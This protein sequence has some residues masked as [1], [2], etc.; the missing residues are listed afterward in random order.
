LEYTQAIEYLKL[1]KRLGI[2]PGLDR[3]NKLLGL[4]GDPQRGLPAVHVAGTNG[5]GSV[6]SYIHAILSNAGYKA[7][8]FTS[9]FLLSPC[10]M[11][12]VDDNEI[13][14]AS[15]CALV[16]EA[17]DYCLK[18]DEE[19]DSPS[20][21]EI[22]TAIALA[23]FRRS[24][25][26]IAVIEACMGGRFDCTNVLDA[27]NAA[28][29]TGI[30]L[31]H[32]GFL[33][34]SAGKIAWHKVGIA[35]P[36]VPVISWP[37]DDEAMAVIRREAAGLGSPVIVP[38]FSGIRVVSAG[39]EGS[40]FDYGDLKSLGIRMAGTHQI[41]N[42]ALAIETASV[43]NGAGWG[44][45]DRSIRSGL[46]KVRLPARFELLR[47]NPDFILDCAHNPDGVK[48]FMRTYRE[49]Y[50]DKKAVV[51]FGV[52]GDKDYEDMIRQ[53]SAISDWFFVVK[54]ENDRALSL[55]I[56]K[57]TA[58]MYCGK[59]VKSDTINDVLMKCMDIAKNNGVICALG[60]IYYAGRVR[61]AVLGLAG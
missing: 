25:C 46:L 55:D 50:G 45:N 14:R 32:T 23:H 17:A 5:K 26:N 52:M 27:V 19:G 21:Y 33:G 34:R 1:R 18:L 35:K 20:E 4:F 44:I 59:V 61:E 6:S 8:L 29:I 36:G 22:Y 53:V 43:L 16:E 51:I 13:D 30:S 39:K 41:H 2:K 60:S 3:I 12:R 57:E 54:P 9:P 48:E 42:A 47:E 40:A 28:V 15:F 11:I 31:D 24:G 10:E 58:D 7:G 38:V 56:L 37:Q 49:L